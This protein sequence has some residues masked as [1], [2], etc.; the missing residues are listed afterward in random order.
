MM[1]LNYILQLLPFSNTP[2]VVFSLFFFFLNQTS[3][4]TKV[5][6]SFYKQSTYVS[7]CRLKITISLLNDLFMADQP[8]HFSFDR[9]GTV[10][11]VVHLS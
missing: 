10:S 2:F 6:L 8:L 3:L 11:R 7:F 1:N 9:I 5:R 4:S